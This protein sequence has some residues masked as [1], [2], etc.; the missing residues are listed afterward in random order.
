[1]PSPSSRLASRIRAAREAANITQADLADELGIPRSAI[2]QI[3][4]GNRKVSSLELGR[5]AFLTG[6][7]LGDFLQADFD[8]KAALSILF[9][10]KTEPQGCTVPRPVLE[11]RIIARERQN[12][13]RLVGVERIRRVSATYDVSAPT[14]R[15]DAISQGERVAQEERHRLGLGRVPLADI[16][17]LIES[18][19]I[20]TVLLELD[21]DISGLT[22]IGK[23]EPTF[24]AVN[25]GHHQ[26]RRRFSFAHEYAH[27]LLDQ[28]TPG[29]V[30]RAS[31]RDDLREM[32][33]N[34]FAGA[35]LM[36]EDGVRE[37]VAELGKGQPS[38]MSAAVFDATESSD[39]I[40]AEGRTEPG[41]QD[42]QLY[43]VVQLAER[44]VVSPIALIFRLKHL[45][46][47]SE[48]EMQ[49]LRFEDEQRR[50]H[51]MQVIL[52]LKSAEEEPD[53][54]PEPPNPRFVGLALDAYRREKITRAKLLELLGLA[55]V[56]DT[57]RD[58]L[59]ASAGVDDNTPKGT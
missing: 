47:I 58:R 36:P 39:A 27:V 14:T 42:I 38:R 3:E 10:T 37:A 16:G 45:K 28:D 51:E 18:Q 30:S 34:A 1:M 57:E 13:E 49:R 15:W 2:V 9:R 12:L 17:Q 25:R 56:P 23:V 8:E 54:E 22:V 31:E 35:F 26:N 43:D 55:G 44:F 24:I 4:N 19:G 50:T 32:R 48:P 5:I 52:K 33:A 46:L 40:V 20:Q 29:K 59:L 41:S 53:N 11:Y 7:D 6:R 21:D